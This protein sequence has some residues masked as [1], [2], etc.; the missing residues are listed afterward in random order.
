MENIIISLVLSQ[1][2]LVPIAYKWE[3]NLKV[4]SISALI[5]GLL[6]GLVINI[7]GKYFYMG[8]PLKLISCFIL[9]VLISI[10][11]LLFRFYRDPDRVPPEGT[12]IILSPADGTIKYIKAIE[13]GEIPFSSKGKEKIVLSEPLTVILKDE[14]GY[15]IGILMT[16]LDVHVTRAPIKGKLTYFKH[17]HGQ[18]HS[19]KKEDAPY[20]NERVIEIIEGDRFKIGLIQ[21]ASRL[22][23]RIVTYSKEG[24]ELALGERIGMITFG[25]QADI[26]LPKLQGLRI[27]TRVGEQ[28]Y[29]GLSIIAEF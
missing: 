2:V 21:I 16:Y 12:N 14:Q 29:A 8:L 27:R 23:R 9:V 7:A 5:I 25:S 3:L 13:K 15:L 26:V 6:V 19:L 22:V 4:V 17:I 1:L 28:V 24:D 20:K 18:F 10:A 11:A